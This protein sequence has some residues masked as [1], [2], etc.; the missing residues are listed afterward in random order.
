VPDGRFKA[1]ETSAARE[2]RPGCYLLAG[3]DI[4]IFGIALA[5]GCRDLGVLLLHVF[6][7]RGNLPP[8][9]IQAPGYRATGPHRHQQLQCGAVR[10]NPKPRERVDEIE[11][12]AR[13]LLDGYVRKWRESRR[14]ISARSDLGPKPEFL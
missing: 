9:K 2:F 11:I 4:L 10:I 3:V 7:L 1:T 13:P 6:G 8:H 5:G 12:K 14:G